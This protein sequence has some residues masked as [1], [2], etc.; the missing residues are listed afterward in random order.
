MATVDPGGKVA[1]A[2]TFLIK[3]ESGAYTALCL[4]LDIASCGESEDEAIESLKHLIALYVEDC[5]KEG[6]VPIPQRPVPFAALREFLQPSSPQERLELTSTSIEDCF[7][8]H[9]FA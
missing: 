5:I 4:E 7:E 8:A 6:D 2:L 9:A 1:L 3:K